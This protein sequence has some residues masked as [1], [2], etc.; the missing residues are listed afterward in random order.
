[1]HG[2]YRT[3]IERWLCEFAASAA[4]WS[5][6]VAGYNHHMNLPEVHALFPLAELLYRPIK[7]AFYLTE[8]LLPA[9]TYTLRTLF[10]WAGAVLWFAFH[11][12]LHISADCMVNLVLARFDV[13]ILELMP[14]GMPTFV[15]AGMCTGIGLGAI[16][17]YWCS[18]SFWAA[19][20]RNFVLRLELWMAWNVLVN[21]FVG[22]CRLIVWRM[23]AYGR[24]KTQH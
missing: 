14:S 18:I 8:A 10:R 2:L 21:V 23:A 1:M 3:P 16:E 13:L 5:P 19:L 15:V 7:F 9:T 11:I 6:I 24:A 12:T 20:K 17:S 22:G 4:G